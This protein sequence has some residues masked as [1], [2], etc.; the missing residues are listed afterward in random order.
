LF[1][2]PASTAIDEHNPSSSSIDLSL[3]PLLR[4]ILKNCPA[5]TAKRKAFIAIIELDAAAAH[6]FASIVL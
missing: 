1:K 3:M 5:S 6:S 4:E 2:H